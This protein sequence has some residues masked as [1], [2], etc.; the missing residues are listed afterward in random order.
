M[1][2]EQTMHRIRDILSERTAGSSD[3]SEARR[4]TEMMRWMKIGVVIAAIVGL[5][6]LLP[7]CT[8]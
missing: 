8:Q 5:L 1:R 2:F 3:S 6:A 7:K 4:H